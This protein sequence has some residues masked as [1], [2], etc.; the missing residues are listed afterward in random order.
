VAEPGDVWRADEERNVFGTTSETDMLFTVA[1]TGV[2]D[3][4]CRPYQ[5]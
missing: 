1:T 4:R 3:A 2:P 5:H